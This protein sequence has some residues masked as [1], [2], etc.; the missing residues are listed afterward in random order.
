MDT[1]K[2]SKKQAKMVAHRGCS[3][4]ECENTAA[5]F[6]AAGNRS[7]WGIETDV[8]VTKDG[9]YVTIHDDRTGR[10]SALDIPVEES[11][12]EQLQQVQLYSH[13]K[14]KT[15]SRRDLV[16]PTLAD[17][18]RICKR[19]EKMAVLELKNRIAT[20]H[21]AGIVEEIRNLAYLENT[22]FISF[23]WDNLVD[24]RAMLPQQKIQFL[25]ANVEISTWHDDLPEKLHQYRFDLDTHHCHV[26]A[27]R[28]K[29]LHEMG[30]EVNCWTVDDPALGEKL[31]QLG[32][33]YITSNILE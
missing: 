25:I 33:D 1:V 13:V 7:Y 23:Y 20:E 30:I 14:E 10:V 6:V 28:V 32:V 8:H 9:K 21:I 24:L 4:L 18:I 5:A 3:G 26:T 12:W 16:I 31:A 22:V 17:Y 29:M 27:E 15:A 2:F 19:Y 11:T